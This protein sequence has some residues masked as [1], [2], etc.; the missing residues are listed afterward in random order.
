MSTLDK[1]LY[2]AYRVTQILQMIANS[3]GLKSGD[4]NYPTILT[5]L[6]ARRFPPVPLDIF[7]TAR[8]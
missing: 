4:S 5:V 2:A 3:L 6:C 1:E 7:T 8:K